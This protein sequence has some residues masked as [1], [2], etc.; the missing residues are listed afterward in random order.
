MKNITIPD[1]EVIKP[2]PIVLAAIGE[3][4]CHVTMENNS[5]AKA[6]VDKLSKS[7]RQAVDLR[8]YAHSEKTC[9]LPW[10]LEKNA[11]LKKALEDGVETAEFFVEWTE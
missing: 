10:M 11:G 6:F 2:R 7:G 9:E 1:F 3:K 8:D 5:S 4:R